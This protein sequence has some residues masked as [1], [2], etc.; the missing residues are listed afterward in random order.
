VRFK[1]KT[2]GILDM[3]HNHYT[4]SST[5]IAWQ[6]DLFIRIAS[7]GLHNSFVPICCRQKIDGKI[8]TTIVKVLGGALAFPAP[9]LTPVTLTTA[10]TPTL[11]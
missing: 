6:T 10:L 9:L 4:M 5:L 1:P 3:K 11:T 8:G 7:A 2:N